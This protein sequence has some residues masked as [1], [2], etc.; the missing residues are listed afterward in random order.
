MSKALIATQVIKT[1]YK[2]NTKDQ[3]QL[4]LL[5]PSEFSVVLMSN[6]NHVAHRNPKLLCSTYWI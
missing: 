2:G 5:N 4:R 3:S 1:H 6:S